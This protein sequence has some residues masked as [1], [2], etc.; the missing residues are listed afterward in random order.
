MLMAYT[1]SVAAAVLSIRGNGTGTI[2]NATPSFGTH[3][4]NLASPT[5]AAAATP[6]SFRRPSCI[7]PHGLCCVSFRCV[8]FRA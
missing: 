8:S 3:I 7:T 2:A 1:P 4:H 5:A 6:S